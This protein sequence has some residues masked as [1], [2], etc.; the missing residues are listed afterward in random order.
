MRLPSHY[1]NSSYDRLC[2]T[3]RISPAMQTQTQLCYTAKL[4]IEVF[5]MHTNG[6]DCKNCSRMG[7]YIICQICKDRN[8]YQQKNTRNPL[9]FLNFQ[10]LIL[11][12]GYKLSHISNYIAEC[13]AIV[14]LKRKH[15]HPY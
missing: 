15:L 1:C 4:V 13:Y 5:G 2:L 14:K 8:Q 10:S 12:S 7:I 9:N 6:N 3:F 11:L